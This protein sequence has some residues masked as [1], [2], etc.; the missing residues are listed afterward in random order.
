MVGPHRDVK[1]GP[2]AFSTS[3]STRMSTNQFVSDACTNAGRLAPAN[4]RIL[5]AMLAT[6]GP[7]I[8]AR[9]IGTP[10]SSVVAFWTVVSR[11]R[12]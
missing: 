9:K 2:S 8:T 4:S 10:L 12:A 7:S 11:K 6:G 1:S 3:T 5:R